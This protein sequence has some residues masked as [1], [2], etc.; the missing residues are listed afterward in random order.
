MLPF[1][2]FL[3]HLMID[4]MRVNMILLSEVEVSSAIQLST[5]YLI[6]GSAEPMYLYQ[7]LNLA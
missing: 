5:R 6:E 2:R 1:R 7:T 4:G 3:G